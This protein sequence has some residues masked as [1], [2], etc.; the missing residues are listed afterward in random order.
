MEH[1]VS[2]YTL[3]NA[4]GMTSEITNLGGRVMSL[5]VPDKN[6]VPRDVVLGFENVEDYLPENHLSDFG[7]LSDDTPTD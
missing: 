5:I 6:G 4:H 3:C 7:R 2:L 1:K